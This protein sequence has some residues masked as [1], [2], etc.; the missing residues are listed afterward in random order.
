ML[1]L[2]SSLTDI[3]QRFQLKVIDNIAVEFNCVT[4]QTVE[5]HTIIFQLTF[6]T[7]NFH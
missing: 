6:L 5:I 1:S 7:I 3:L 2:Q 4:Q